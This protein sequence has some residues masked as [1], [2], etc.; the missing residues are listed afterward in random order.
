MG[1]DYLQ[2]R[3]KE[4][5]AKGAERRI[6]CDL[7]K[8]PSN[9]GRKVL[10]KSEIRLQHFSQREM[11]NQRS[12]RSLPDLSTTCISLGRAPATYFSVFLCGQNPK[13]GAPEFFLMAN[14]ILESLF[15]WFSNI[16]ILKKR[17]L[18]KT[19]S[20]LPGLIGLR[21]SSSCHSMIFAWKEK[22]QLN[23]F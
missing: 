13:R 19:H 2:Q 11:P 14:E 12:T 20:P 23:L 3:G 4:R 22:T 7:C 21:L 18:S 6:R 5:W 15:L 16:M 8:V 10:Q 1:N 17:N 9:G